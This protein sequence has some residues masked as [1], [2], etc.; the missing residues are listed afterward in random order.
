MR[1]NLISLAAA[2][3]MLAPGLSSAALLT[4]NVTSTPYQI[5]ALQSADL[6]DGNGQ[7]YS[8]LPVLLICVDHDRPITPPGPASFV[9]GAGTS[10][11]KG[12]GG[13]ASVAALHWLIDQYYQSHIK[14]GSPMQRLAFQYALWEIGNDYNG[15]AASIDVVL[16]S[17]RPAPSGPGGTEFID[18]YE[19]LYAAMAAA[20]PG[21]PLNYRSQTYTLDLFNNVDPQWQSM[22]AIVEQAPAVVT[23]VAVPIPTLGQWA[24][25]LL[26]GLVAACALPG[27]RRARRA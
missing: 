26:S 25:V 6:Q 23:P 11:I 1:K 9:S 20:L 13:A 14:L 27:L 3:A 17:S 10:A 4:G 7:A 8:N 16:G 19:A 18:A 15:T 21:L 2:L 22:V 12:P 24:L 5:W